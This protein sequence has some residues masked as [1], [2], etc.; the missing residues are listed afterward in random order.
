MALI[1]KTEATK[2]VTVDTAKTINIP[3]VPNVDI[4]ALVPK[5]ATTGGRDFD[6]EAA[7]K[8]AHGC[9]TAALQSPAL[10]MFAG[11][12]PT[13]FFANVKLVAELTIKEVIRHQTTKEMLK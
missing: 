8:I 2:P 7:G 5:K 13:E 6:A 9:Y 12:T 4:Q 3:A 10:A 1:K 11:Q